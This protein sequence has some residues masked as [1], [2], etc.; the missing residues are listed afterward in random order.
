ML[1]EREIE[2]AHPDAF[3]FAFGNLPE[4]KQAEFTRHL[5]SCPHC[6]KVLDEY[7]DIGRIIKNLP[8]HVEPPADLEDRT[9]AAM[10]AALAEQRTRTDRRQAAEDRAATRVY[11]IPERQPS[12]EPETRVQ[13]R[14]QL[15]P[16]AE[17]ETRPRQAP[18][19]Q[20]APAEPQARPL[21]TRLPVWRRY[22]G[23][24]AAVVAAAAAIITAA[25]V[26]PLSL[27]GPTGVTVA[28]PLQVTAE[29][30]ASGYGSATGHATARQD[31]S[32]S[33]DVT[34]TVAHLKNFGDAQWYGCWY[35]SRDSS[36]VASA[37]TFLVPNSGSGTFS[38]TS[39][40]DP[41]DFFTMKITL[42][43]PTKTGALTGK[44]ILSGQ[45]PVAR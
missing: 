17:D 43:P 44:V 31:A 26:V 39:A 22:R 40:A 13:P 18:I 5:G 30:T 29:G 34:L 1:T 28:I 24:L 27:G 12:A 15:Q 4:V 36:Q 8:P 16:P 35:V 19:D 23:R 14:P 38:M 20:P 11:P 2:L 7:S 21:V 6:Q 3:D 41:R 25:I 45:T 10:V 9:V 33:W 32:G 37:G 42:G